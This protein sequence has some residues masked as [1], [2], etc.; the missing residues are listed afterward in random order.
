M[1]TEIQTIW[2][3]SCQI[4][5]LSTHWFLGKFIV[6]TPFLG[7]HPTSIE[8]VE[9]IKRLSGDCLIFNQ[10]IYCGCMLTLPYWG[11]ANSHAQH[12]EILMRIPS[13][14]FDPLPVVVV[15]CLCIILSFFAWKV[16]EFWIWRLFC[17]CLWS[18][19]NCF[20]CL[21]LV[22][23]FMQHPDVWFRVCFFFAFIYQD[24]VQ[25]WCGASS[26]QWEQVILCVHSHHKKLWVDLCCT[27]NFHFNPWWWQ[28]LGWTVFEQEWW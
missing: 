24:R 3:P 14:S 28:L 20:T 1:I 4:M 25:T 26:T 2:P 27:A 11:S 18:F 21:T 12:I 9:I 10:N 19:V 22:F 15:L 8:N 7:L 16:S 13:I 5:R 23:E 6:I 17:F